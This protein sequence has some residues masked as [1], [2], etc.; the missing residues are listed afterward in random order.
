MTRLLAAVLLAC[1]LLGGCSVGCYLSDSTLTTTDGVT[2]TGDL[3]VDPN[4]VS[5]TGDQG[6]LTV[7][8]E[9]VLRIERAPQASEKRTP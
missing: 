7:A 6:T 4:S 2:L 5:V 8:H 3:Y 9:K 1:L